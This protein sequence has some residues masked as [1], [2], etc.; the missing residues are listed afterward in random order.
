M[1]NYYIPNKSYINKI[2]LDNFEFYN[3]LTLHKIKIKEVR[4]YT[5]KAKTKIYKPQYIAKINKLILE[6]NKLELSNFPKRIR[7]NATKNVKVKFIYWKSEE[8]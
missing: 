3:N 2:E 8:E 1:I 4:I 6:N 7:K 5:D